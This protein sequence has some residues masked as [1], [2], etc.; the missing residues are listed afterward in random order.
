MG[1]SNA[2]DTIIHKVLSQ[3]LKYFLLT[4]NSIE[5]SNTYLPIGSNV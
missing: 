5:L 1:F 4:T 2:F 3:K